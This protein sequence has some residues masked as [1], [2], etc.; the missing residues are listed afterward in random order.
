MALHGQYKGGGSMA[1]MEWSDELATG[2]H[3]IDS[4]HRWLVDTTNRL[5]DALS[6]SPPKR[7]FIAEVLNRLMDY[8][9]NHFIN[10]EYLFQYLGYPA[11]EAHRAE[12]NRFS[13]RILEL[14]QRHEAGESVGVE[15]LDSLKDWLIHHTMGSD[16]DY[17]PFLKAH[18]IH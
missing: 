9:M 10:E 13:A 17:V 5:H 14:L 8:T 12:H 15:V 11:L 4:R 7:E 1:F 18:G 2:V 3:L 6:D 16:K